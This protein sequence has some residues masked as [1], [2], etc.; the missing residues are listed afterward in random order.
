MTERA[1]ATADDT[2]SGS[3]TGM[4]VSSR[5]GA[6]LRISALFGFAFGLGIGVYQMFTLDPMISTAHDGVPHWM[7]VTHIHVLGL[8]L[9]VFLYSLV[10]DDVF[11][12]RRGL[13]VGL[14]VFGQ[15][16]VPLTLYPLMVHELV[17]LAPVQLLAG[18]VTVLVALAF[19]VGYTRTVL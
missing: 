16:G 19:A 8:S 15:W 6:R 1:H 2:A 18:I 12:R 9:V 14:T 10:L 11:S 5:H 4:G 13:I 3:N 7:R 17:I